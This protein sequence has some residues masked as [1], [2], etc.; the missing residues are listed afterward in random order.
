MKIPDSIY[1]YVEEQESDFVNP[2]DLNGWQWSFKD[3]VRTSFFYKHG[4]LLQG[5]DDWTPVKN[6]IRPLLNLQYRTED[7]DVKDIVIYVDDPSSFHLSFLVKK[8]HD[9]V[10]SVENDLGDFLDNT[11]ES[12]VDFGGSLVKKIKGAKPEV[13]DLQ[14]IAFCDQTNILSAPFAIKHFYSPDQ[15]K[16]MEEN[17]WGREENGATISIDDLIEL[18][19]DYKVQDKETG[20][21]VKT[22]GKYVEVYEV[23]GVLPASYLDEN[24]K[25][26]KR[27]IHIITFT[28]G[29]LDDKVGHTLFKKEVKKP[30]FKFHE[31]DKVFG[32][33]VGFGGIEELFEPQV[34]TNYSLIRQKEMLDSASKVILKGIGTDLKSHYPNGLRDLDNLEILELNQGE[35]I[36]QIDTTPRSMALFDNFEAKLLDHAQRT[37][38]ATDATLGEN[39]ASGTP[40][41]LQ[42]RVVMEGKGLH[43]YR[44]E[45]FARFVEEIY[46]DWII[47]Y[48]VDEITKGTQFLSELSNDEM[49]YVS[50]ALVESEANKF[51]L[52]SIFNGEPVSP[53]EVEIYKQSVREKFNKGGSKK[54]IKILKDEFKKK[55]LKV[56]VNVAGKQKDLALMTDKL[57]NIFRQIIGN[58]QGFMQLMQIPQMEKTFNQIL[59]YSGLSPAS[60]GGIKSPIQQP[61]AQGIEPQL[62]VNQEQ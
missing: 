59:E 50:D 61:I 23:H 11:N 12:K 15:L 13:V 56:K 40:F 38:S 6:I 37:A 45:K 32:R 49:R 3:H 54:F 43:E 33:C 24:S 16:E 44:R 41:R 55:Q 7:L 9:D 39:P 58:P 30:L 27:Q 26:Y 25:G 19:E 53:E 34:W 31:R 17:G 5:N 4:R 57:V 2:I 20:Q 21:P 42:E 36:G 35:D 18:A 62:E 29:E 10:F 22:T 46:Q 47:P 14:S 51:V 1:K 52:E 60:F 28:K 48:I 8:Y